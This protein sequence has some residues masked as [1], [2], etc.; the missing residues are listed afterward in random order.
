MKDKADTSSMIW[1][2]ELKLGAIAQLFQAYNIDIEPEEMDMY[3]VG[4]ILRDIAK[5]LQVVRNAI[6]E[7]K[8]LPKPK[9][10]SKSA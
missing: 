5:D 9:E 7:N 10:K 6:E 3:G 1:A 8:P 2:V 4:V